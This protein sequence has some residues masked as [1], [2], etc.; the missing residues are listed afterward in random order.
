MNA[1]TTKFHFG[2]NITMLRERMGVTKAELSR[3][4]GTTRTAMKVYEERESADKC[5]FQYFNRLAEIFFITVDYLV[6]GR[7]RFEGVNPEELESALKYVEKTFPELNKDVARKAKLMQFVMI[8]SRQDKPLSQQKE[9][10]AAFA[11]AIL[12]V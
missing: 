11:S 7:E 8:L 3:M 5:T 1:E 4:V 9:V 2:K 6:T 12:N 10:I